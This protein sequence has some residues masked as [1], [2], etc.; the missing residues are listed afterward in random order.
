MDITLRSITT[1]DVVECGR[2]CFEAFAAIANQHDFPLDFPSAEVGAGMIGSM[3]ANSGIYGIVAESEGRTVGSNFM[4]ERGDM[5][6]LGPI[7]V[8]PNIQDGSVGRKLM[9][10]MIDRTTEKGVLGVRLLQAA[11]HNRSLCLYEKLGFETC[12]P[13]SN[14]CGEPLEFGL[15]GH[16]VRRATENDV[17]ACN[18]ICRGVHG[19]DR[20]NELRDAIAQGVAIVVESDGQVSGYSTGINFT[21]HSVGGTNDALKALIASATEFPH[22]GFLLPARNGEVF[23][24]C[25]ENGLRQTQLLTLMAKGGYTESDGPYLCSILY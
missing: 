23:R 19:F 12:E 16:E 11:Y 14:L 4:D 2:I 22:P 8:D 13:I 17:Q 25:L 15:P 5:F 1:D 10:H 7:T 24:W 9:Q 20:A 6:G 18:V 3:V 21:G